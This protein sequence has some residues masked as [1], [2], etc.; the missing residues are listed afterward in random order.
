[1][2]TREDTNFID[3]YS[4]VDPN[5]LAAAVAE[6]YPNLKSS[7]NKTENP[8]LYCVS[9]DTGMYDDSYILWSAKTKLDSIPYFHRNKDTSRAS[10]FDS[11]YQP[12]HYSSLIDDAGAVEAMLHT[13]DWAEQLDRWKQRKVLNLLHIS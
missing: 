10:L 7:I 9:I 12:H 13:T 11:E 6:A 4:P 5:T 3:I 8:L 2:N 1:M